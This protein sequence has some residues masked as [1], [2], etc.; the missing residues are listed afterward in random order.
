[1]KYLLDTNVCIRLLRGDSP[2]LKEKIRN[3]TTDQI[4][5][6]AIV[7][8][9]LIY[10]VF[11]SGGADENRKKLDYF[12]SNIQILPFD[13]QS[14]E[15]AGRK[16]H[17]LEKIGKPIGPYDLLIPA[18]AMANGCVLV[19]HNTKEFKRVDGIQV[20]DWEK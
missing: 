2:S 17:G 18:L 13:D 20:E 16:R 8:F 12:L 15:I 1:M 9:E 7:C 11:K 14:A 10:G 4:C 6:S 19:T 3:V 5:V